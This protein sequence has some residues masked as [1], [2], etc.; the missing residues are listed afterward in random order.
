LLKA[1]SGKESTR[2]APQ[3]ILLT[4]PE[5]PA[6]MGM[7]VFLKNYLLRSIERRL[8]RNH[9]ILTLLR[10]MYKQPMQEQTTIDALQHQISL[11][12]QQAGAIV[13]E[14]CGAGPEWCSTGAS[15]LM[16]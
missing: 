14:I 9:A 6:V 15:I 7:L 1:I 12:D 2:L 16:K 13:A 10:D 8:A 4:A 5:L 11:Q 3:G